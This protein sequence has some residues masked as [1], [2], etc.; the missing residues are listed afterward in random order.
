MA[1]VTADMLNILITALFIQGEKMG[2]APVP[3]DLS[4]LLQSQQQV[5]EMLNSILQQYGLTLELDRVDVEPADCEDD[6]VDFVWRIKCKEKTMCFYLKEAIAKQ[7][8]K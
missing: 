5:F 8:S 4:M 7:F 3:I 2:Q 1:L 6:C